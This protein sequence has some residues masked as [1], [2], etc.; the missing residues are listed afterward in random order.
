MLKCKHVVAKA[1]AL[2]DGAPMTRRE[3]FALR[4]HLLMCHSLQEWREWLEKTVYV[5]PLLVAVAELMDLPIDEARDVVPEWPDTML[6][7]DV[8]IYLQQ[9]CAPRI[10]V[11][12]ALHNT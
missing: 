9:K 12:A 3:R 7:Q 2:V 11:S 1:D 10:L 5:E 8:Y 6:I 4:L